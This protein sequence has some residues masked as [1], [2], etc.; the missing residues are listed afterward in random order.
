M[1][2]MSTTCL[3][4]ASRSFIIGRRLWPPARSL[5]SSRC[6]DRSPTASSTLA[7]RWYSK[8][9]GYMAPPLLLLGRLDRRPDARRR[10]GQIDVGDPEGGERV[11]HGVGHC[12]GG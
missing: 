4:W 2:L 3:G 5:A 1:R 7:T 8:L 11:D 9:A 6:R 12:R 10:Q